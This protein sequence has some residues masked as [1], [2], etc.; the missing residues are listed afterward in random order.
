M[1]TS[2]HQTLK[3]AITALLLRHYLV[4]WHT[5]LSGGVNAMGKVVEEK[6]ASG[7]FSRVSPLIVENAAS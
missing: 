2:K 5:G 4:S 1:P 6:E 7:E 3:G